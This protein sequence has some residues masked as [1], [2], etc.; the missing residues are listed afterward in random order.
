[1]ETNEQLQAEIDK[2]DKRIAVLKKRIFW[3][4][5]LNWILLGVNAS[6]LFYHCNLAVVEAYNHKLEWQRLAVVAFV[7]IAVGFM[8]REKVDGTL[9]WLKK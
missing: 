1:M 9:E 7:A 5:I 8:L 4:D 6:F 2:F 3:L